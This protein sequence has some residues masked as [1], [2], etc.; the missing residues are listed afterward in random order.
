MCNSFGRWLA[1]CN[2]RATLGNYRSPGQSFFRRSEPWAYHRGVTYSF[3][4]F[5]LESEAPGATE[6][7]NILTFTKPSR[8]N[9][10]PSRPSLLQDQPVRGPPQGAAAGSCFAK[11]SYRSSQPS[12]QPAAPRGPTG[13]GTCGVRRLKL[14]EEEEEEESCSTNRQG[15]D[16][17]REGGRLVWKFLIFRFSHTSRKYFFFF[18]F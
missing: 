13:I 16:R 6:S 9:S 4:S 15:E 1:Y 5:L 3:Q 11:P 2:N 7:T 17:R 10:K 12:S 18:L 14:S 8:R